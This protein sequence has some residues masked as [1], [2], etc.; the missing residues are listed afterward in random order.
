MSIHAI[1]GIRAL[2]YDSQHSGSS[3]ENK[4]KQSSAEFSKILAEATAREKVEPKEAAGTIT[5][6]RVLPDGTL[7]IMKKQGEKVVSQT[8]MNG[9]TIQQ[10]QNMLASGSLF[11]QAYRMGEKVAAGSLF[12]VTV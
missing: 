11:T 8:K 7:I 10:Q 12:S 2:H 3:M 1:D 5:V 9:A 6:T 4:A